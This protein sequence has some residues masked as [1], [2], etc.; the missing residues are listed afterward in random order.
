MSDVWR[1]GSGDERYEHCSSS[2]FVMNTE[3]ITFC[4]Y[5]LVVVDCDEAVN[6]NH[7]TISV[8]YSY[9]R[10]SVVDLL[11][12]W[13]W[14]QF[15]RLNSFL[16][17]DDDFWVRLTLLESPSCEFCETDTAISYSWW[18]FSWWTILT[19]GWDPHCWISVLYWSLWDWH[20]SLN[21]FLVRST[22]LNLRLILIPVRLTL[23]SQ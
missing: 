9:E 3:I 16:M 12:D 6:T 22:L 21:N 10:E 13:F 20:Y 7:W 1:S 4:C 19:S 23:Q 18:T 2:R 15:L 8:R 5:W 17:T 14:C 11:V